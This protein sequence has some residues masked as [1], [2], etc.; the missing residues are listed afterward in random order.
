MSYITIDL[1]KMSDAG[2]IAYLVDLI[3]DMRDLL[4]GDDSLDRREILDHANKALDD[5]QRAQDIKQ[6]MREHFH[7]I[8][9]G[10][11]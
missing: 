1:N 9:I 11:K 6:F 3:R 4:T 5:M 7:L 2:K 10:G 8:H